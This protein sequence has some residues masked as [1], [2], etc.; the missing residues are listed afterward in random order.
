MKKIIIDTNFLLLPVTENVDIY[1][2]I[3]KLM[4]EP[5]ELI[6]L[7]GSLHEIEKII[8][9]GGRTA[10]N[11]SLALQLMRVRMSEDQ[12]H[13]LDKFK[14]PSVGQNCSK[15]LEKA[16]KIEPLSKRYVD[17]A[18]MKIADDQTI[19]CTL[20]AGLKRRLKSSNIKLITL[21]QRSHLIFE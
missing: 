3:E 12:H 18:I 21:R 10:K 5:Y 15:N 19:V 2:A 14:L 6:V 13:F 11:A 4:D 7:E 1:D 8:S 9:R 20:D 17:D 16:L